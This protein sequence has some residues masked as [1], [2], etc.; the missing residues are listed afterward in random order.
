MLRLPY[1]GSR[2]GS[3]AAI[4]TERAA[5]SMISSA[6]GVEDRVSGREKP[7]PFGTSVRHAVSLSRN[8]SDYVHKFEIIDSIRLADRRSG[9]LGDQDIEA[10]S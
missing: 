7:G 8:V 9:A 3:K 2:A 4:S 6:I 10:R 5:P 1:G